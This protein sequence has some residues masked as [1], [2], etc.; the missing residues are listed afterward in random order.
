M[1]N[2]YLTVDHWFSVPGSGYGVHEFLS[3]RGLRDTSKGYLVHDG[4]LI[5]FKMDAISIPY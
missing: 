2:S 1:T 4:L 3:M 5:E